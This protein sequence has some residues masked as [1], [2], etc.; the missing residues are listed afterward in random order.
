V[1][2]AA[3]IRAAPVVPTHLSTATGS[4]AG[5]ATAEVTVALDRTMPDSSYTALT[6]VEGASGDLIASGV[7]TKTTTDVTVA[8]R[9]LNTLTARSGTVR[10]LVLPS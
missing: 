2:R 4:V 8:L 5:G 6:T 9:N 1:A 10:V 3:L 7:V